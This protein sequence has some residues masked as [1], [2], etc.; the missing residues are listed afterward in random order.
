MIR[1]VDYKGVAKLLVLD[2]VLDDC[3]GRY[4]TDGSWV[5]CFGCPLSAGDICNF[6]PGG[7]YEQ[8]RKVV[9]NEKD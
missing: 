6:R 7:G 3:P 4:S 8:I 9:K 2:R 1:L 5:L